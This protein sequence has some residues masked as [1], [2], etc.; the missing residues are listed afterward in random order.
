MTKANTYLENVQNVYAM[1]LAKIALDYLELGLTEFHRR[2]NS[3][4]LHFQVALGNLSIAIE[5]MLKAY[6]AKRNPIL[7]LRDIPD[8]LRTAL[9]CSNDIPDS[10]DWSK[11]DF[12]IRTY[13]YKTIEFDECISRFYTFFP[14]LKHEFNPYF[15]AISKNRNQ[16]IHF[17][18]P[19]FQKYDFDRTA[20]L[21]INLFKTIEN[22]NIFTFSHYYLSK[23]DRK[24]ITDF[25]EIRIEKVKK[26]IEEAKSKFRKGVEIINAKPKYWEDYQTECPI[27][28]NLAMLYGNTE[29]RAED[30]E[31][32]PEPILDFTADSLLCN[33]CGLKLDDQEELRLAGIGIE[34]DRS[35]DV[36]E[37][38]ADSEGY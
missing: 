20:Y 33:T 11:Y 23:D 9:T 30:G 29:F 19:M 17:I 7:I 14:N 27:C 36:N 6:L 24:F 32:G 25:K 4:Y 2:R 10:F 22:E 13:L 21:A 26:A 1:D 8:E 28:G 35:E 5:L 16:S 18:F 3:D 12:E 38:L 34:Y 31:D 15:R 37:W